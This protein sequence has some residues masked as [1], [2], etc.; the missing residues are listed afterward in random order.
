[1][2]RYKGNPILKPVHNHNWESRAVFN[3]AATY[4]DGRVHVL[5]R[6]QGEDGISRIGYASSTDGLHL[7]ER[8]QEP[9]FK[10]ENPSE[11]DGCEDPRLSLIGD[12]IYM[13]YTAVKGAPRLVHQIAFTSI[14][15]NDL[16]QKTW[17][18]SKRFLPFPGIRNKDG[19]LLPGKIDG[20]YML[21]HR[22]DPD[23]CVA[24]SGD[25]NKW[26]DMK[27]VLEPRPHHELSWDC[28]KI[29]IAG[30]PIEVSEGWLLIYHG[31]NHNLVYSLGVALLDKKDPSQV[32]WRPE[33]PI[34][35]PEE[36]YER[37]GQ[38]PNV[39]FSCG[40]VKVDDQVLVYYGGADTVLCVASYE[41]NELL[42]KR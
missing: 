38:V 31:V 7:D 18:W 41:L 14:T 36:D 3:A 11:V 13:C 15:V 4:A 24:Y 22:I 1:L 25:L 10:P 19:G 6:G 2:K 34:L 30:P 40:A 8:F 33:E 27:A 20:E 9:V 17:N 26:F 16:A 12:K 23:I 37:M 42:P 29:G 35:K 39:V 32:L 28:R 21:Y 5:Y